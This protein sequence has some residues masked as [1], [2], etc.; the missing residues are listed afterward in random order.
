M[1]KMSLWK[2]VGGWLRRSQSS[3][4]DGEVAP[5]DAEGLM[6][7]PPLEDAP[8]GEPVPAPERSPLPARLTKKENQVAAMEER[9]GR[10]VDVLESINENVSQHRRHSEEFKGHLAD[11]S[12][13]VRA[14]PDAVARQEEAAK[15]LNE[16]L[17]SQALRQQQ[18]V[19][20][21]QN[22]PELNEAQVEKLEDIRRQLSVAAEGDAQL[23]QSLLRFDE[24]ADGMLQNS[25]NQT[26][27]VQEM[28]AA[29]QNNAQQL[30]TM[31]ARQSRRLMLLVIIL[32]L[33][34][35]GAAGMVI[36]L[37]FNR[38]G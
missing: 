3:A 36:W 1:A 8:E 26:S 15:Q 10:L 19:E 25:N 11:L 24:A 14:V 33:I 31:L 34:V 2:R 21:L 23:T 37:L 7:S 27:A 18:L 29:A 22:L 5:L 13:T 28:A 38:A 17:R 30:Q 16:E 6:I 9:F 4:G 32:L 35:A 12:D 20:M